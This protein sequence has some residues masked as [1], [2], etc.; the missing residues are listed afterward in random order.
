[1]AA[2]CL[3]YASLLVPGRAVVVCSSVDTPVYCPVLAYGLPLP[4][5]ADSQGISPVGSVSR[6]PLSLLIGEDD[7][8]WPQLWLAVAFWLLV[9]LGGG[10]V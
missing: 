7:L 9:V 1:V 8:L 2:C 10:Y 3:T 4:F 5:L 6:D